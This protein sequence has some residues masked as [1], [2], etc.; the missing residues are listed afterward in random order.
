MGCGESDVVLDRIVG[1]VHA[2]KHSIP[3]QAGLT[4]ADCKEVRCGGTIIDDTHILT[5]A[6]CTKGMKPSDIDVLAGEH[7]V[8]VAQGETRHKVARIIDHPR[9]NRS[10]LDYDFS[11][12]ELYCDD[13]IDLTD[14]ARAAC[15]P[16]GKD[17]PRYESAATFNVSGWGHLADPFGPDAESPPEI[18]HVV[19]VSPVPDS[20]CKKQ[21]TGEITKQMICAGH[22]GSGVDACQGDSGGPL[23]WYDTQ[24]GKWK[25]VGVVSFGIGCGGPSH[26]GVYAEVETVLDWVKKNSGTS[27]VDPAT[28]SPT[29]CVDKL[30]WCQGI[31]DWFDTEE[32]MVS[33]CNRGT[34]CKGP[35]ADCHKTCGYC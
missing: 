14:K 32:Q 29:L 16:S 33:A 5:A 3:W 28:R 26:S 20:V 10:T 25:L 4:R 35:L 17:S 15:L 1:G 22:A 18:L 9:Y 27:C 12:L 23:T 7:D 2:V 8:T 13:K 11:I 24:S 19:H 34:K 31:K 6:H 21:H 30:G